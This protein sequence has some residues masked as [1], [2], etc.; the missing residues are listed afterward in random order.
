LGRIAQKEA[1]DDL[2]RDPAGRVVAMR[3][4]DIEQVTATGDNNPIDLTIGPVPIGKEHH[5]KLEN[6]YIETGVGEGKHR[7]IRGSK[8]DLLVWA[9]FYAQSRALAD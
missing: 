2:V 7:R 4:P 3:I 8:F 1:A 9:D 6:D 5:A